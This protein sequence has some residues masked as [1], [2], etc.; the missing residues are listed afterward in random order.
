MFNGVFAIGSTYLEILQ[1]E[2]AEAPTQKFLEKQGGAAGYML[3]LQVDDLPKARAR[4][5]A[6]GVRVVMEMPQRD[7]VLGRFRE[8]QRAR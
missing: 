3:I 5:E 8:D 1:P 6:M 4:A 7:Y 2:R